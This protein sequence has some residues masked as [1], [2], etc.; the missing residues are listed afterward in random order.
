[1]KKLIRIATVPQSLNLLFKGQLSFLSRYYEVTG[2]A[3]NG[4]SLNEVALREGIK[5]K[6]IE[7]ERRM[8]N[9]LKDFTALISLYLYFKKEKPDIVHSA[10]PKAG[11][12]SMAAAKMAGVPVRIHTFTGLIFPYKTGFFQ[13]ILILADRIL[14]ACATNIYPEGRGVF[15][16]ALNNHKPAK[17]MK[18]IANGNINGIDTQYFSPNLFSSEQKKKLRQSLGIA[19]TDFVFIFVG[20]L[21]RGKGINELVRVFDKIEQKNSNAKLLLVGNFENALDPLLPETLAKMRTCRNIISAGYQ[22]DVRLFFAISDTL[23]FPSYREGFPNVVMQAG[24]MELPGIVTDISGCNEIVEDGVN[25][26][27]IPPKNEKILKEKMLL[28]LNSSEL[29]NKLKSNARAMITSRYE[30]KMV[31]EAVLAEYEN[32]ENS[33]KK[34]HRLPDFALP[35]RLDLWN[36][37][38]DQ[39]QK[40]WNKIKKME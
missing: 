28:L 12:L 19:L 29:M 31:W 7:M 25:G 16:V 32:L 3:S 9:P 6:A 23:V 27:I 36:T 33:V 22:K 5:V 21:V 39:L 40:L 34:P 11:L 4:S 15:N 8:N 24:A 17:P 35:L 18:V 30:Q 38:N 37:A 10:T 20:R 13:K 26:L 1:M 14:C 2:I